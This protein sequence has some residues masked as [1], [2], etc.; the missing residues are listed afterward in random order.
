MGRLS[1]MESGNEFPSVSER[2]AEGQDG[3]N[4]EVPCWVEIEIDSMELEFESGVVSFMNM[5]AG[6]AE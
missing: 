3:C 2:Q 1:P 4:V 6:G 5:I